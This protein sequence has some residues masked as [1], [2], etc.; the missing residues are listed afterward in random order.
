MIKAAATSKFSISKI[1]GAR[2]PR[3][4]VIA[5]L[6]KILKAGLKRLKI[7]WNEKTF[8]A[9]L[10]NPDL[11][12]DLIEKLEGY[13]EVADKLDWELP[14]P[15]IEEFE[16]VIEDIESFNPSFRKSLARKSKSVSLKF[17]R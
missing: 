12:A 11:P 2:Q 5:E 4:E 10:A 16:G 7:V 3:K 8:C 13:V 17:D 9:G 6:V 1:L 15:L 14:D